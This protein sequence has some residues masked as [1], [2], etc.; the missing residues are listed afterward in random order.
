MKTVRAILLVCLN[1]PVV[2]ACGGDDDD[3]NK[4]FSSSLPGS[5]QI[6]SLTPDQQTTL[7]ADM[8]RFMS[9]PVILESSKE[10]TCRLM[11]ALLAAFAAPTTDAEARS[12]CKPIYDDCKKTPFEADQTTCEPYTASCTATIAELEACMTDFPGI[13]AETANGFPSCDTLSLADLSEDMPTTGA[14]VTLTP[15]CAVIRQKCPEA[16]PEP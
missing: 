7:C 14:E 15:A 6:G 10:L 4:P 13:L 3:K 12:A 8:E 16:L 2:F 1:L 9:T 11:G 5:S